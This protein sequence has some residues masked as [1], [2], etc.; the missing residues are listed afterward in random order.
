[1]KPRTRASSARSRATGW[2]ATFTL[3]AGES[4][5]TWDAGLWQYA[6]IGDL[7]WDDVDG[8]GVYEPD[9]GELPLAG[10][11]VKLRDVN[12][13]VLEIQTTGAD[14]LYLFD[15]LVPGTYTVQIV[16]GIPYGYVQ[17]YDLDGNLDGRTTYTLASGEEF[18]GADFGY[19]MVLPASIGDL[20]WLDSD[21]DGVY[22]PEAG[23]LP[24]AG[25]VVKLLDANG[26]VLEMQ[27]T[28]ADGLYLFDDLVPGTY[29]VKILSGIPDGYVQTYDLDGVLDNRTTYTLAAGE[30]FLGADFGYRP[31]MSPGTGTPGYWKN[32]PE[33]W[34]VDEITIGGIPYTVDA[35]IATMNAKS[36][37]DKSYD[38]FRALVSAKLNVGIGN[39]SSCIEDVIRTADAWMVQHPAGSGV[40]AGSS[41]WQEIEWAYTLLDNYNNGLL[42]APARD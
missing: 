4:D 30:E 40:T 41:A 14:G 29:T 32:H 42:C 28:G 12:G 3:E 31:A 11:V 39:E 20:V 38:M 24:L 21:A 1:M 15:D 25:V 26:N 18:L 5:A 19:Q 13:N 36:G 27:T 6:S 8:D 7:V 9:A 16:S 34:P 37:K 17:T 2:T 22:E 10:V 23:E 35:A 33:A